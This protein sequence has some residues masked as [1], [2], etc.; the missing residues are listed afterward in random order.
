[1]F[2]RISKNRVVDIN[3]DE[4][5]ATLVKPKETKSSKKKPVVIPEDNPID[6]D[7]GTSH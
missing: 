5:K 2:K 7:N 1:M 4:Y 3:S 6:I